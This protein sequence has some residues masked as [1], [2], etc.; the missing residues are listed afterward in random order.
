MFADEDPAAFSDRIEA[1]T[2]ALDA[3]P[4]VETRERARELV[5][6]V[7]DFHRAGLQRI[8]EIAGAQAPG[9]TVRLAADPVAA[10]LLALH[11]LAL[12]E[13][14]SDHAAPP[15]PASAPLIQIVRPS[16]RVGNAPIRAHSG[17]APVCERCGEPLSESHH[18]FVE[19]AAR[20]LS[21]SC[22]ACWLLSGAG[23][24]SGRFRPVPDRYVTGPAFRLSAPEWDA[25][26]VPVNVAFFMFN[27]V[28]GRMI[29]FY[30]SPAGATE[31][32]LSLSAWSDVEHANPWVRGAAPD[33]EA[34]LVR[35]SRDAHAGDECFVVPIDACYDLVGRIR[36]QW[37]GFDGGT[38]V[39]SEIDRF[40][41]EV[42][43][44]SVND[45]ATV[46]RL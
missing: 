10:A 19:V 38:G 1:L 16:H 8:V 35:K 41:A 31:S 43:G 45:A 28:I 6:S 22:R 44:K 4:D 5:S 23:P 13:T 9:L 33:V 14:L 3:S 26:Q 46:G 21:C 37:S 40:F 25:L 39:R 24:D 15:P 17:G 20:R 42:A 36:L 18:H 27:S 30:P 2:E 11:E 32:A 12:P 7:L 34:I 29:A